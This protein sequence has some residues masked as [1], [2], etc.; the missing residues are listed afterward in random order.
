MQIPELY[1]LFLAHPVVQTDTRKLQ[2]GDIFFALKGPNFNANHF[3]LQALE[4]GAAYA[5]V[6]E[7]NGPVNSRIILVNNVL[8][9]LQQLAKHRYSHLARPNRFRSNRLPSRRC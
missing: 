9:S 4:A 7:Y 5:V 8:N 1:K 3:A 6:D 2:E